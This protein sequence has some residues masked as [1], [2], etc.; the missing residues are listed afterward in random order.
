MFGGF[1]SDRYFFRATPLVHFLNA[2]S[3]LF[4][5]NSGPVLVRSSKSTS[6]DRRIVVLSFLLHVFLSYRLDVSC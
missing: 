2:R 5:A 4:A 1:E 6:T 3:H